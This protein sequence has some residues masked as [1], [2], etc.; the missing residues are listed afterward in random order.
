MVSKIASIIIGIGC[1]WY[2][3]NILRE[4]WSHLYG[5]PISKDTGVVVLIFGVALIFLGYFRKGPVDH[6]KEEFLICPNCRKTISKDLNHEKCTDCGT[7]LETLN[8]FYDRH[9]ELKEK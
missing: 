4:G 8:G 2:G 6:T 9:P 5:Y 3:I 7:E 1:L